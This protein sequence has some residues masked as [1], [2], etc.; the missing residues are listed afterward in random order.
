MSLLARQQSKLLLDLS[1]DLREKKTYLHCIKCKCYFHYYPYGDFTLYIK[2]SYYGSVYLPPTPDKFECILCD[3]QAEICLQSFFVSYKR[4][5][6]EK[7]QE[8][9][10][11]NIN[12]IPSERE[13]LRN[14]HHPYIG[15]S[16]SLQYLYACLPSDIYQI[17]IND[18]PYE[19]YNPEYW[20]STTFSSSHNRT[21]N[22]IIYNE[23]HTPVHKMK[24]QSHTIARKNTNQSKT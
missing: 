11:N 20:Y 14:H 18:K 13:R 23:N 17:T 2:K 12:N 7:R 21:L 5:C 9:I 4:F 3:H 1:P 22:I 6:A 8:H 15:L 10:R 16:Y 19:S 24:L